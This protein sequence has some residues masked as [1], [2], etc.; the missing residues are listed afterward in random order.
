M[1]GIASISKNIYAGFLW[2]ALPV[3]SPSR[4]RE[5][6]EN[7]CRLNAVTVDHVKRNRFSAIT[8]H[9]A[10]RKKVLDRFRYL[11]GRRM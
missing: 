1:I 11:H 8:R 3:R 5:V 10:L 7:A 2:R 6:F 4:K 9:S